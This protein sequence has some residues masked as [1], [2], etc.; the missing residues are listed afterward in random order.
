MLAWV[1][2]STWPDSPVVAGT[3]L[4]HLAPVAEALVD[5]RGDT[6]P[7]LRRGGSQSPLIELAKA[8]AAAGGRP[9]TLDHIDSQRR[10][11]ALGRA[12]DHAGEFAAAVAAYERALVLL[13]DGQGEDSAFAAPLLAALGLNFAND[14]RNADARAAFERAAPLVERVTW[15]EAYPTYLTYRAAYAKRA[16]GLT[17]PSQARQAV[18][19]RQ[20]IRGPTRRS[21][22]TASRFAQ[23]SSSSGATSP[24]RGPTWRAP[25]DLPQGA[26]QGLALVLCGPARPSWSS[27]PATSRRRGRPRR[28][29]SGSRAR[30]SATARTWWRPS[31]SAPGSR[32][33]PGTAT[34]RL[35]ATARGPAPS[36]PGKRQGVT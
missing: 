18:E 4:P 28:R 32:P 17:P 21:W 6:A 7:E 11:A 10:L 22:P 31:L 5:P 35:R 1:A 9:V 12:Y 29:R 26:G 14:G 24:G 34:V 16:E 13:R 20:S 2:R 19:W 36:R 33:R 3:G 30:C 8:Q 27:V 25:S 23:A 15:S